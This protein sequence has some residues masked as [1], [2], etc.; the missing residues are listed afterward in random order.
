MKYA[1]IQTGGHQ[2]KVTENQILEV[3]RLPQKEGEI[4]ALTPVLFYKDEEKT[5]IGMPTIPVI[6]KVEIL[7]HLKGNKIE[8]FKYKSKVRYRRHIGFRPLLTQIKIVQIGEKT[9]ENKK[10]ETKKTE[11]AKVTSKKPT[12][13]KKSTSIK[14][15]SK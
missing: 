10:E 2:F 8:V 4:F 5:E 6:V 9:V 3:N 12:P 15:K 11:V 14:T 1:I 13:N 7:K